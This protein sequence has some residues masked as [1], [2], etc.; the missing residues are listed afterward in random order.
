MSIHQLSIYCVTMAA[1]L[2]LS[3]CASHAAPTISTT[4]P[5]TAETQVLVTEALPGEA[6]SIV[7]P[8]NQ[9]VQT[10]LEEF[11]AL[12]FAKDREGM[13]SYLVEDYGTM[14]D[15]SP[16]AEKDVV[17]QGYKLPQSV[18]HE[19]AT[20]GS[21]RASVAFRETPES[22]SYTYLSITFVMENDEWKIQFYGLEK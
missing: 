13:K 14:I 5:V 20:N 17:I 16:Y 19:L 7:P 2:L 18:T 11:T 1:V 6:D 4:I 8:E 12:Y 3:G 15:A 22:D 9:K 21:C 10:L